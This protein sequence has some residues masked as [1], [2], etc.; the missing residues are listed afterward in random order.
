M[1]ISALLLTSCMAQSVVVVGETPI[2][3]RESVPTVAV[4]VFDED[5]VPIAGAT[6]MVG[7]ERFVTDLS[8]LFRVRWRGDVIPVS[9][10][11]EG[12]FP[13]ALAIDAFQEEPLELVLR[14]VVLR[15]FVLDGSNSGIPAAFVTLGNE[16]AIT[17]QSGRFQFVRALAGTI[18][19]TKPGW[20]D[21][22]FV[23]TGEAL[24][25]EIPMEPMVIKGLH[26][27]YNAFTEPDMWEDLLKVAEQT[28]VNA[29]VIDIKDESGR[30]FYDTNVEFAHQIRAVDQLYELDE[31]L[32]EMDRLGLYKIARLTTFQD[33]IAARRAPEL[34]IYDTA[35]D[36]P[37]RLGHQFFLDPT[38]QQARAYALDLAEDACRAGFDEIQ[39]DYVR[40]PDGY[41]KGFPEHI[42]FDGGSAPETRA[43]VITSFL[44]DAGAR[45]HPLGCVVAADIF[46]FLT[47]ARG[48]GGIG[49]E[50]GALSRTVDV[51]SPMVYP[52]HYSR[53]WFGLDIPNDHP[54]VVVGEALSDG[55]ERLEGSAVIRPWLQDFYYSPAQVRQQIDAAEERALGWMLWNAVSRFQTDALTP[56][57]E[58]DSGGVDTNG[59]SG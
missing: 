32:A 56:A 11:A 57:T 39:F 18:K 10:E 37:F 43:A 47:S 52:S 29:L 35:G 7:D 26:I 58:V 25:E 13:A 30:V 21:T 14:A 22:E 28:V 19:V 17:D 20:H 59:L 9:V 40:F 41:P 8:G 49:Q 34:A 5:R 51:L 1:V 36:Q 48:D 50:L 44:E 31:V 12:F 3:P 2:P 46:G 42:R 23:W 6:G 38:D 15:G 55:I 33:P 27:A 4:K 24:V 45:L 16:E 53:G 54:G